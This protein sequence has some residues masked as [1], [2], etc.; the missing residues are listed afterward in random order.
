MKQIRYIFI[1]LIGLL[2]SS[3]WSFSQIY[4]NEWI[5]YNQTYYSFKI[6]QTGLKRINYD[7][8]NA[9]GIPLSSF[10]HEQI[11][12]FGREK[13]IPIWI[14]TNGDN[15]FD[16]GD[17]ILFY[18][19]KND[20]WLDTTLYL[21]PSKTSNP[22]ISLFNDTI[23]YFFTWNN[24]TTNLRF[25][26]EDGS[27]YTN[28][29]PVDY[30][31]SK[32]EQ[33]YNNAYIEGETLQSVLS[34]SFY[35]AGEGY[36]RGS[37]NGVNG[38]NLPLTAQTPFPYT[39]SSA[40]SAIFKGKVSTTASATVQQYG[41]QNHHT[42][43]SING[44]MIYDQTAFGHVQFNAYVPFP[45]SLLTNNTPLEWTIV[46]DLPVAT[47]YQSL[48]YWSIEYPRIPNFSGESKLKIK[49][50]NSSLPK[51]RVD[52]S[53]F[54]IANPVVFSFGSTPMRITPVVDGGNQ[55]LLIPNNALNSATTIIAENLNTA[56]VITSF[57]PI[58]GNGKFTD[59]T[60]IN[61]EKAYIIVY[62]PS[63]ENG[64]NDY[65]LYR[66]SIAGGA[67][68][69]VM[70]N[71]EEL[72]FQYGG[73]IKKH[74]NA[75]R[76][77]AAQSY[78]LAEEKPVALFLIGKGQYPTNSRFN[79]TLY[80]QNL[81]PTFG[82]PPSDILITS[83]LPGTS[84]WTPLIP[85]GRLSV[86]SDAGIVNY[87][88][89]I[90]DFEAHQNQN[91]IYDS[92]NKDWQKHVIHLIGGSDLNQQQSFFAQMEG[93][94]YKIE[95][96]KFGGTVHTLKRQSDDPV[97][98]TDLQKIMNRISK[99]VSLMTYYG[100]QGLGDAGFEINLDDVQ[101][102][103]NTGKY[104]FMLVNS[105]Y[106][107][108]IFQPGLN[109]S[110]EYFVNAHNVGAIGYVSSVSTGFHPMVG[111][112]SN[113]LYAEFG[114]H[115]YGKS[116]GEN[117]ARAIQAQESP[118][119]MY[120]EV[121]CTQMLLNGDP[122][123]KLNYHNKPEI[124]LTEENVFFKPDFIDLNTDSIEMNI[125]LKNLGQSIVDSF[126]IEIKRDF[127]GTAT[128][129]LYSI[130]RTRLDY[131]DTIKFKFPLQPSISAGFN[132]FDIKVDIPSFI[133][134]QYDE[135][136]NNQITK[137]YFLQLD[138]I[139]PVVPYEFAVIPNDTITL[140][141]ST[142]NPIAAFN[143]Y[144]FQIDTTDLFN[145][146]FL[147]NAVVSGL[148]GVKEVKPNQWDTPLQFT[149][150]TVYFWR[151]A[152]D[153]P[154]PNWS[155]SSFQYIKGKSGWGQDH[156]FQFKKNTFNNVIYDRSQ[157]L[158]RWE[159]DYVQI[160]ADVFNDIRYEN[161]YYI[162]GTLQDYAVCSWTP[163]LH[164]AV[165]DP[166]TFETW[167]TNYNGENPTH[168]FGNHLCRSRVEKYF[169]FFQDN[170]AD[171][172]AF[173]N[174][175]LN[176]V[177]DGHYL[178]IYTPI[179]TRYDLWNSLD[180][181]NMYNTFATLGSDS[182]YA[183]RPNAPFVFFTRK[184]YPTFVKE[185]LIDPTTG[186]G[187]ES[188]YTYVGL[189]AY[190]PTSTE[191]GD[192]TAPLIGPALKWGN[193]YW[194]QDS[195][196]PFNNADTT[197]L[198][199]QPYKMDMTPGTPINLLYTHNDSLLN[200]QSI[201][202]ASQYPY[203]KL[204]ASYKDSVNFT[205]AQMDRWHVLYDL[206]PEAAIDGTNGYYFSHLNDSVYEGQSI[207]FACDIRNIF[208]VDMDSLLIKYWIE[209]NNHNKHFV[210]YPRQ[211][212]LRVGQTIRDTV[213][214]TTGGL[215]GY[216]SLW[217]EVNPYINGS[218]FVTDQPEQY[219]FNN[220]LQIP[221]YVN[222]DDVNPILD[223]TFD[224]RHI[225]NGDIVNPNAEILITLK[226][227]NPYLIMNEVSDTTLFGI[228][229]KD[230]AGNLKRIPF[231][232]GQG[233]TVMQ[234]IPAE[235]NYKKFKIIYPA[236]FSMDGKYQLLV[237]GADRSGNLSGD[238][239]YK[240]NFEVIRASTITNMMNYPNPFSTS[241]RFVFTLTGSEVPDDIIIQIMT[242]TG[243][244]VREITEDQ[245]GKI[246]IGRNVSEYAWDGRDEFGD[247]LANGVYLY[248]VKAKINGQ[249][250][251]HRDSG[252]DKY[253]KKNFGKMY[254]MR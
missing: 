118:G 235:S 236:V 163:P 228:Y 181:A 24:L 164:V 46:G 252:A 249:D 222:A 41:D 78:D 214:F 234:W 162:N 84:V 210:N 166:F 89:K 159:A 216:N 82:I 185:N 123:L 93:M 231:V 50:S 68:N 146:P 245:L 102:W 246:Y 114:N 191:R 97:P 176:E 187:A 202:N 45:S 67:H 179:T 135:I 110:S 206:A 217:V 91:D 247:Q 167:G 241:T 173:Q 35:V 54:T 63:L 240:I 142:I 40:P 88:E 170:L 208:T 124:E 98:P 209:D 129:S 32:F 119:N 205:P 195:I 81:V 203:I 155:E 149:D 226:D 238:F 183:G 25:T 27:D 133:S 130:E 220:V 28:Y 62:P 106:N 136:Y 83:N 85:T 177:P 161:A 157:R 103:N 141:A 134:E 145:S 86:D 76:R 213:S 186:N 229:L 201:V 250:I 77:F 13:E 94:R 198:I 254:L 19:E 100:H 144:R 108:D 153:E 48:S 151:V 143:T 21:D 239:Q 196:D 29:T 211:D 61:H 39:N 70:A 204:K 23:Y 174:M 49:V 207:E 101:N 117:M 199:I 74:I 127:P 7:D 15:S 152:V 53:N 5:N 224:G 253:F 6:Y 90:T 22:T 237:Q 128:D 184:G 4:G 42:R 20:G 10:T 66:Q 171:L 192:E 225:L 165:V 221:F 227:D 139:L 182:I 180:S 36:G 75:I 131:V 12:L 193:V 43:F 1:F 57:S 232:D 168:D 18:A 158:R 52:C 58:N 34:S 126:K 69:V 147:K 111:M 11:Q 51:S 169:V 64:T 172:Q 200:L 38:Y 244:V 188:G 140:K 73:G 218:L 137:T 107:G 251:E 104:P 8:L 112:Y 9:A 56:Q 47:M 215:S 31:W 148:G 26:V 14:E 92:P 248:T 37:V 65:K 120:M 138:G 122:A 96:E 178:L 33:G 16:S 72:Y 80:E 194:K 219:H 30:V 55:V 17:Y 115:S 87:L 121:T 233:N 242:V 212:S 105:C 197:R 3:N 190:M 113:Q 109:S 150:S 132:T 125:V 79:A 99:G 60:S 116:M 2:L 160:S 189:T 175:V 243:R 156:F 59:Y 44:Q 71:V 154:N 223:V 95:A 230:P